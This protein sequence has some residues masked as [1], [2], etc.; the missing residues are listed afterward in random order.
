MQI[1]V[2]SANTRS[3]CFRQL[4]PKRANCVQC[5][6]PCVSEVVCCLKEPEWAVFD[7]AVYPADSSPAT[8]SGN[9]FFRSASNPIKLHLIAV[10]DSYP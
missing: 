2:C 1:S 3:Q 9:G 6:D 10:R 5:T 4:F 8:A 7:S